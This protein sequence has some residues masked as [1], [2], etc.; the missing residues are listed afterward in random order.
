MNPD[1][2]FDCDNHCGLMRDY[3]EGF[4]AGFKAGENY[5]RAEALLVDLERVKW[6]AEK[7]AKEPVPRSLEEVIA[8]VAH[9]LGFTVV[10]EGTDA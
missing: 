4:D 5:G 3:S 1:E 2:S 6:A 10:T 9:A 7:L 8:Q